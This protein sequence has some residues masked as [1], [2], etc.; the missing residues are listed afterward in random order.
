MILTDEQVREVCSTTNYPPS[1]TDMAHLAETIRVM[2]EQLAD[3][4]RVLAEVTD[5][6]GPE[7]RARIHTLMDEIHQSA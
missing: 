1:G 2:R 3:A 4:A 6:C 5:L 7:T